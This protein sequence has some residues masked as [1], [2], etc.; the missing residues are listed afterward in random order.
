MRRRILLF[1]PKVLN[2]FVKFKSHFSCYLI[3]FVHDTNIKL[4]F[5]INNIFNFKLAFTDE[6]NLML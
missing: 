4:N 6:I 2:I 5:Q 1:N 3:L